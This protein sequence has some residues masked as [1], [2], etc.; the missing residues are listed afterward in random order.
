MSGKEL[1]CLVDALRSAVSGNDISQHGDLAY[2]A[3]V[4]LER[5]LLPDLGRA[6]MQIVLQ[7]Q[8]AKLMASKVTLGQTTRK[9]P[10]H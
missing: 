7:H 4:I 3:Q 6:A 9:P 1:E 2:A 10:L 5:G 8:L